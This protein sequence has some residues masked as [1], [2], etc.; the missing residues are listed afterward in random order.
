MKKID[1]DIFSLEINNKKDIQ[2]HAKSNQKP[3]FIISMLFLLAYFLMLA[4]IFA[5]E[6]SDTINMM[7]GE[8]SLMGELQVLFGVLTA[9]I[10]Q[11]L[12]YWFGGAFGKKGPTP[13]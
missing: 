13:E 10:G 9:G 11:I 12:S 2:D 1:V 8:N 7:K 5:I 4:A 3:Q 6:A